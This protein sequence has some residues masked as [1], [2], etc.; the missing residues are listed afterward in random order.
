MVAFLL[1]HAYCSLL[2]VEAV[3]VAVVVVVVL[4]VVA[5]G[6]EGGGGGGGGVVRGKSELSGGAGG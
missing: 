1:C 5:E 6:R 2:G 4:V 3:A